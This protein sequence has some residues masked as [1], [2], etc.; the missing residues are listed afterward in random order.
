[1]SLNS[2]DSTVVLFMAEIVSQARPPQMILRVQ[3]RK[4]TQPIAMTAQLGSTSSIGAVGDFSWQG[5][6]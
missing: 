5:W 6:A 3:S 1:M 2:L 4:T